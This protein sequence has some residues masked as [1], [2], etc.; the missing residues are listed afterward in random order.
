MLIFCSECG[1][2]TYSTSKALSQ[3]ACDN[4]FKQGTLKEV[5]LNPVSLKIELGMFK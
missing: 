2:R 1:Y 3:D 4:C 5:R